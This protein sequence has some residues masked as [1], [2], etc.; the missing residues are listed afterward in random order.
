MKKKIIVILF[1]FFLFAAAAAGILLPKKSFSDIENRMLKKLPE[2]STRRILNGSFMSDFDDYVSDHMP[3]R[4]RLVQLKALLERFSGKK[5]NEG[6]AFAADDTLIQLY[7]VKNPVVPENNIKYVNQY[8]EALDIPVCLGLIP[9]AADIWQEKLAPGTP[10]TDEST[11]IR[12]LYEEAVLPCIDFEAALTAHKD[13]PVFY[14]TDQHWTTLGAYYGANALLETLGMNP[15]K[16][17]ELKK[18]V[19]SDAFS[20][21]LWSI[22]G[23]CWMQPDVM[24]TFVP[25][26]GVEVSVWNSMQPEEGRM[27]ERDFLEKKDKY[28]FFFG[29][30]APIIVMKTGHAGP[31]L[32]LVR[33]SYSSELAPLLSLRFSEIHLV[34]LRYTRLS[35]QDYAKQYDID[36]A[37]VVYGI[38]TFSEDSNVVF[39]N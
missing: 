11:L 9:T 27:Y 36:I 30:N 10:V 20:G 18:T 35:M 38:K 32:L 14:R 21:T 22:A 17:E 29:G 4:D 5:E 37:A 24:E 23:A 28:S 6:I 26:D 31:K 7:Q 2:I 8:S 3:L 1:V 25:E 33:D 39:L 13:E 15:I 12:K 16:E 34:D 19:V